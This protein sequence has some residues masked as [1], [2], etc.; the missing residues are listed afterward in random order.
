MMGRFDDHL[1]RALIVVGR[2]DQRFTNSSERLRRTE[3]A[4]LG[5]I[6]Y[7]TEF[8]D[9]CVSQL[10]GKSLNLSCRPADR[11]AIVFFGLAH[12]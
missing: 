10:R 8:N 11:K 12:D 5:L 7:S 3:Y 2:V 9:S 1:L 6:G 4:H